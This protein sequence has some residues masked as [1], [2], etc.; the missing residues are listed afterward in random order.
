MTFCFDQ[1]RQ[2]R[3]YL[4]LNNIVAWF[5]PTLNNACR[6]VS[7][8]SLPA[9]FHNFCI[10]RFHSQNREK[11][12]QHKWNRKVCTMKYWWF[13]NILLLIISLYGNVVGKTYVFVRTCVVCRIFQNIRWSRK[14]EKT[15][16][17]TSSHVTWV[18]YCH[19]Y[20]S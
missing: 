12:L 7:P 2:N 18:V 13:S 17:I 5:P 11:C 8:F 10:M 16:N 20:I 3:S 1:Q 9:I 19:N 15:S 4:I 6:V 14:F